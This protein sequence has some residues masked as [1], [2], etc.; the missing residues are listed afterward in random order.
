MT[1]R[2]SNRTTQVI[3]TG[4]NMV[5]VGQLLF[6]VGFVGSCEIPNWWLGP[7]QVNTCIER[8][9]VVTALFYPSGKLP[10]K[11]E[12]AQTRMNVPTRK[13]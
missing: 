9:Y 7:R 11:A 5:L 4:G 3:A 6:S 8:W 13:R 10:S 12:A 1:I 2:Q